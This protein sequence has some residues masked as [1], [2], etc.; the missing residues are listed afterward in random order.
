MVE[1][2]STFGGMKEEK[3]SI[4]VEKKTIRLVKK[5]VKGTKTTIGE[6]FDAAAK[7]ILTPRYAVRDNCDEFRK[8]LD[9]RGIKYECADH[10]TIILGIV[11]IYNIGYD[12]GVYAA[13]NNPAIR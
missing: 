2:F 9:G 1:I 7:K 3:S 10:S 11:D 6:Y 12:F 4:K 13:K 5:S 8:F